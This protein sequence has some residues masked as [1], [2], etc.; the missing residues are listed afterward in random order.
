[1]AEFV[2]GD[3]VVIPFPFSDL[4][5]TKRRPAIILSNLLGNDYIMAQI[6]SQNVFDAMSV[7]ID[8]NDV[9]KGT[10][11]IT[12]NIRPNKLFTADKNI[13]LYKI[14]SLKKDKLDVIINK[15]VDIFRDKTN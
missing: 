13:V 2:K 14:C 10:L 7:I 11:N 3:I 5:N 15:V 12:S 1:M 4:S 6:T 9:E 8:A